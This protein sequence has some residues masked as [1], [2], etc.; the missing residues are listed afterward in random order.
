M[1]GAPWRVLLD[2]ETRRKLAGKNAPEGWV[3]LDEAARRLGVSKQSVATW[4]KAGKL[5]AVRVASGR[6]TGWRICV[7]SSDLEKQTSLSLDRTS[8]ENETR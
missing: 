4:V 6:R 2:D 8:N 3:G 5:Q 7:D 1:P